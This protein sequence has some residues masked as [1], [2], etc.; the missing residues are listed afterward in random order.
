MNQILHCTV[1]DEL[2]SFFFLQEGSPRRSLS[3][4]ARENR[5]DYSPFAGDSRDSGFGHNSQE[6]LK[7]FNMATAPLGGNR[8][9]LGYDSQDDDNGG[10]P[11]AGL[12]IGDE[13]VNPDPV[14][15][16]VLNIFL[17]LNGRFRRIDFLKILL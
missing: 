14:Y 17:V 3:S 1:F 6:E 2:L 15:F 10:P 5:D 11:T 12:L 4:F 8:S 9:A 13:L 7:L 16:T